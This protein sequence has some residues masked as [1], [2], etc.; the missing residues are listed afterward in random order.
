MD[1]KC[2]K[3]TCT[4]NNNYTCQAKG[5]AITNKLACETFAQDETKEVQDTSRCMFEEA[6]KYA[7]HRE[8]KSLKV[9]CMAKC[10]FNEN[11]SCV[12]NGL[13]INPVNECPF[14]MTHIKP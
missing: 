14:C 5:I 10:L 8:K 2:R 7:P 6:P 4:Y 9:N 1:L 12:A 11:G 3:T 13:T